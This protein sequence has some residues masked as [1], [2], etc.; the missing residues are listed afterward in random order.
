MHYFAIRF[1]S[2]LLVL[3]GESDSVPQNYTTKDR[4][5]MKL[6]IYKLASIIPNK[7]CISKYFATY[8]L[9]II[10]TMTYA[11]T[12]GLFVVPLSKGGEV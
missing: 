4:Q 1:I 6:E 5:G 8:I 2:A 9:G 11:A 10:A 7:S 12:D 3:F